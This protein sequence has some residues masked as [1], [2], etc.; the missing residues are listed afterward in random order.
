MS[1]TEDE[2]YKVLVS[3]FSHQPCLLVLYFFRSR[4]LIEKVKVLLIMIDNH[5]QS[6]QCGPIGGRPGEVVFV[7]HPFF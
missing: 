7:Y 5:N 1:G 6:Y 4:S 2:R 3:I